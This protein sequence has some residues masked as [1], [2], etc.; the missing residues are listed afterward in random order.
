MEV[1]EKCMKRKILAAA[2]TGIMG[3]S[4]VMA[5]PIMANA[6]VYNTENWL[7][8]DSWDDE[9]EYFTYKD[10]GIPLVVTVSNDNEW[11]YSSGLYVYAD[12]AY[13]LIPTDYGWDDELSQEELNYYSGKTI[14]EFWGDFAPAFT[15]GDTLT[16]TLP[17][18]F[19][20]AVESYYDEDYWT[21]S[22]GSDS[23]TLTCID[24]G[25]YYYYDEGDE[26]Y[27]SWVTFEILFEMLKETAP[28]GFFW[29]APMENE[30]AIAASSVQING[31]TAVAKA[32][33]D[34]ALSYGIM[35]WLEDHPG[36]ILEY[37]LTYDGAEHQIVIPGGTQ[38]ANPDIPWYGPKYLIQ[39]FGQ[40]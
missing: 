17:G 12:D 25:N 10:S 22:Y 32:S 39:Y 20:T 34:Y 6:A 27:Y 21:I 9:E 8:V 5:S 4:M 7:T 15:T 18:N 31:G 37:T 35:K 3:I 1:E 2:M 30:L 16:V 38:L 28:Q 24:D 13:A 36:V 14:V 23:V 40:T 33:G 19:G 29:F 26:Y 11:A